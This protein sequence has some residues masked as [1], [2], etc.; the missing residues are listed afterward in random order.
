M[1]CQ[2]IT[3]KKKI[4]QGRIKDRKYETG[5]IVFEPMER[6]AFVLLEL[7]RVMVFDTDAE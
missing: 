3:P 2:K 6:Y 5:V 4:S 1:I 7:N